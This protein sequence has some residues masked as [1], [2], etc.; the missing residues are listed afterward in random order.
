MNK[1]STYALVVAACLGTT[2]VVAHSNGV[3]KLATTANLEAQLASDGAF[4]DG[5]YLGR[6]GPN[7]ANRSR[8]PS[9]VGPPSATVRCSRLDISADTRAINPEPYELRG[10]TM[11]KN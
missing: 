2:A 1:F 3:P 8:L 11:Q 4:R 9:A 10:K 6:L 7:M 5:L